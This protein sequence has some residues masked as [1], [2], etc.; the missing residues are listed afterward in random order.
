MI[1]VDGYIFE[2]KYAKLCADFIKHKRSL[3][4]KYDARAVR[5]VRYLNKH[6]SSH[7]SGQLTDDYSLN[8]DTVVAFVAKRPTETAATQQRREIVIR[9]FAIYLSSLGISAY[10]APALQKWCTR[11]TFTPYIFTS[12]QVA[13]ILNVVDNLEYEYRSPH[14]HH[15]YP[16]LIRLLYCCGLRISEALSLKIEDIDFY[17]NVLRIEQAKFNNSRLIPMSE[18][19]CAALDAYMIQLGYSKSGKG[20]LFRTKWGR[21]YHP[22]S[23]YHRFKDFMKKAGIPSSKNGGLPRLH[24]LRHTFAIHSLDSMVA[25]GLDA[26]HVLPYLSVF[27]GHRN[28]KDTEKYLRLTPTAFGDIITALIPLYGDL[29]HQ[30]EV[31]NE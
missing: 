17:E 8:K 13:A 19:L 27:M 15:V 11:S 10:I 24:D 14:F 6:L 7:A 3:G 21:A 4:Y 16:L 5:H 28:I 18:S 31:S 30:Q 25:Q 1:N 20:L 12:K 26:Y 22:Q 29:F 23:V 2:G 9:Q